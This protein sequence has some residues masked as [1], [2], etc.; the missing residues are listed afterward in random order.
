MIILLHKDNCVDAIFYDN[1]RINKYHELKATEALFKIAKDFSDQILVWADSRLIGNIPKTEI[2]SLMLHER[3]MISFGNLFSIPKSIGYIHNSPF[4]KV[5]NKVKY[6]TWQMSSN[7]GSIFGHQ[8]LLFEDVANNS[9]GLDYLLSSI[10]KLG[11]PLGLCCYRLPLKTSINTSYSLDTKALFSFVREHYSL[12]WLILL[13]CSILRFEKRFPVLSFSKALLFQ[14]QIKPRFK[15]TSLKSEIL[16][17][18]KINIDVIIPTIGRKTY[19]LDVL[20][21]FAK[22]TILPKKIIIV[23]QNPEENSTTDLDF[24]TT[25]TW[26]FKIVHKFI[27]QTGAC[28]ARNI[29]LKEVSS[30]WVFLADDDNRFKETLIE[31]CFKTLT[32]YNAKALTT[33]YPQKGETTT[34]D[35]VI[36]W[37]T[38]GSGNSIIH[39]SCLTFAKFNEAYEHGYGEDA[40]F[41]MQLRNNGIDVLYDPNIK[42]LHLKAPIGGFRKPV[43]FKWDNDDLKPKPSPTV[44]LFHLKHRTLQQIKGY[45]LLLFLKYY[46][47]QSIKNPI[48]YIRV[49]KKRWNASVKW[50]NHLERNSN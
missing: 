50:A 29:A 27:N 11:Q 25:E 31:D 35:E 14:R 39:V 8:L 13:L 19:L 36:Q 16:N 34:S 23:E 21:D 33:N 22:Q 18:D 7:L 44:M 38:F 1:K 24:I 26:P 32:T 41:G 10:A 9:Q 12:K 49:M 2:N 20:K 5:N 15:L 46:R 3:C 28:N 40:D 6:P 37:S 42:I 47:K 17:L 45:K 4:I 48:R 30:N 43:K